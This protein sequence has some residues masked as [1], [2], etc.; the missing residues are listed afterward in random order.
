MNAMKV[1]N[2]RAWVRMPSGRRLDLVNPTPFDWDNQDLAI[3]LSRTYRWGGHSIW[4]LPMSVAQHSL[5]VLELRRQSSSVPL[6]RMTSLREVAHD[7]D[8]G[9]LGFDC[10]SVLKP[11]LGDAFKQL[12]DRLLNTVFTRYGISDWTPEEKRIHKVADVLAA[13]S[14]AIH[15]A[16]W[17]YDEL[18]SVLGITM[19]PLGLYDDPLVAIYGGTPWEP[20]PAEVAAKRF[21]SVLESLAQPLTTNQLISVV[22]KVLEPRVATV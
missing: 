16:G 17:R 9:L 8:E 10:I 20:W 7:A 22:K 21:L 19:E 3:G 11:V 13:A 6:D 14:E 2:Q 15:V 12:S 1:N 18:H 5:L 4:P